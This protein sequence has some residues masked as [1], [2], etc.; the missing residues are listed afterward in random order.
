MLLQE[1]EQSVRSQQ[2]TRLQQSMEPVLKLEATETEQSDL[3]GPD[4]GIDEDSSEK[5]RERR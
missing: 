4:L 2:E 3:F 5:R 1:E